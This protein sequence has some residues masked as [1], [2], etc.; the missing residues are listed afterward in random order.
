MMSE[1]KYYRKELLI[2]KIRLQGTLDDI[3]TYVKD[4]ERFYTII[5]QSLPYK[6]N[7]KCTQSIEYRSYMEIQ[8]KK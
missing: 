4:M 3:N 7:R 2:M 5:H 6:N 1:L 8:I